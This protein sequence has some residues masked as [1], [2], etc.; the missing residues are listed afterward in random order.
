MYKF[1]HVIGEGNRWYMFYSNFVRPGCADASI[2]LATSNDGVNWVANNKKLL[3]G[4]DG[5][6]LK[7]N[8]NKYLI[9]FGP[10][11]YFDQA[12]CDIRMAIYQ[13]KLK[14]LIVSPGDW[15]P[16]GND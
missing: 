7:V 11:G 4:M 6:I 8:R 15:K 14:D 9:Y 10:A 5:E 13:G 3:E 16:S 2:R 12:G 1:T